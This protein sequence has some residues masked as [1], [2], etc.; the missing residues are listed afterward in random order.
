MEVLTMAARKTVG[1]R[2]AIIDAKITKK[3]E[4]IAALEM[5]KQKLLHPVTMKS[6]MNKA[7]ESG[8]TPEEIAKKLGLEI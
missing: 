3:Q 2:I 6:V 8:L 4:E 5:Q 1:E 7:K